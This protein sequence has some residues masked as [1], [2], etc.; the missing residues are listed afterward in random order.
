MR[1]SLETE[2][3]KLWNKMTHLNGGFIRSAQQ[4]KESLLFATSPRLAPNLLYGK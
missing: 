1:L 3:N 4:L 2:Y